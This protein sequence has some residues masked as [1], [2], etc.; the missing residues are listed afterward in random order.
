MDF[1][2]GT[3]PLKDA[4]TRPAVNRHYIIELQWFILLGPG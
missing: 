2:Q 1:L 3:A 4:S